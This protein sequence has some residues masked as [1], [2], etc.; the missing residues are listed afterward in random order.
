MASG[1]KSIIKNVF[2]AVTGVIT[3]PVKGA[4]QGGMKGLSVGF[5]KGFLGLVCKP[6]KGTIDLVTKTTKGL[7]NTPRTV[8]V[9]I[10]QMTKKVPKN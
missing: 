10:S 5:G 6:M 2:T 1:T 9:S 8:Y 4:K 7:S 3:E